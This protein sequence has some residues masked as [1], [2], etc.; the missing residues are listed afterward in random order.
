MVKEDF[1]RRFLNIE[2]TNYGVKVESEI[3]DEEVR[4]RKSP[5]EQ[6]REAY[7]LSAVDFSKPRHS[8]DRGQELGF[9]PFADVEEDTDDYFETQRAAK[10]EATEMG[11]GFFANKFFEGTVSPTTPTSG[12]VNKE[13]RETEAGDVPVNVAVSPGIRQVHQ[14]RSER[15]RDVDEQRRAEI[16]TNEEKWLQHPD[17]YDYPGVDT[18]TAN[19]NPY[20]VDDVL[21]VG[22]SEEKAQ[23][24]PW[25]M[26]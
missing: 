1:A 17:R 6:G 22:E 4:I 5:D 25:F 23:P 11:V 2:E 10:Q 20:G 19:N 26:R 15:A 7:G 12:G 9:A 13:V 24:L 16:T 18:P 8:D 14:E 3:T 21:S